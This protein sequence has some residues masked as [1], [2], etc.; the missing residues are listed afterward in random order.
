[1]QFFRKNRLTIAILGMKTDIFRI[2]VP[3]KSPLEP[4]SRR[5]EVA[6]P[7]YF[8]FGTDVY[9]FFMDTDCRSFRVS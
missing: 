9:Y 1:M 5:W 7:E 2:F 6:K 3:G 4:L 8:V